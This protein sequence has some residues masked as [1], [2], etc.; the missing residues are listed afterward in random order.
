[1]STTVSPISEHSNEDG[2]IAP[3]AQDE[4]L[5]TDPPFLH[6]ESSNDRNLFN[7]HGSSRSQKTLTN[8]YKE[9]ISDGTTTTL[10]RSGSVLLLVLPYVIVAIFAWAITAVLAFRPITTKSYKLEVNGSDDGYPLKLHSRYVQNERWFE[11]ARVLESIVT[12]L[13]IPVA[14]AVCSSAAVIFAQRGK[15]SSGLS[16]RQT[17][18]L[19]NR[20]WLDLSTYGSLIPGA[21]E[22]AWKRYASTFLV[23]A[24]LLNL[25]GGIIGPLQQ[26]FLSTTNIKTPTVP[27]TITNLHDLAMLSSDPDSDNSDVLFTRQALTTA[28]RNEPQSQLWP[29]INFNSG[30]NELNLMNAHEVAPMACESNGI[31]FGN[32]SQL[33][34]PF[35]AEL[36]NDFNSGVIRQFLP[37]INSTATYQNIDKSNF[38]ANCSDFEGAF[39]ADLSNTTDIAPSFW[40]L[41]ACMPANLTKSPWKATGDRQDFS[42]ELYLNISGLDTG[43]AGD[44]QL[45]YKIVVNTTAGFFELPNY[46][47]GGIAGPLLDRAPTLHP[48]GACGDACEEQELNIIE[49]DQISGKL[50]Y[51]RAE[52]SNNTS[53][54]PNQLEAVPNKGPLLT[55]ALAL[56]GRGSYPTIPST[57]PSNKD[58]DNSN[59]EAPGSCVT[60]V[61]FS[62]LSDVISWQELQCQRAED[63]S[64]FDVDV[65]QWI[66]GFGAEA[67][68]LSNTFTAAAFLANQAWF[69]NMDRNTIAPLFVE[70]DPGADTQVPVISTAGVVV[71]SILLGLFL[72]GLLAMAMYAALTPRWTSKL[73]AWAMM[74]IGAEMSDKFPLAVANNV[75]GVKELDEMPGWIGD[76]GDV[77]GMIAVGGS[78]RVRGGRRYACYPA[79][80]YGTRGPPEAR[81]HQLEP[82]SDTA[83][84]PL[85][86]RD[87]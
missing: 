74:R 52:T 51:R 1:M 5:V 59:N 68:D 26:I 37:R 25:L 12:T 80:R 7:D 42:E 84:E 82:R 29:G 23:I 69:Q 3:R 28:S 61:P 13:T 41:Q 40:A 17:M 11:A 10:H 49:A 87:V 78:D 18:I 21:R 46:M 75:D 56:F 16:M 58:D 64:G 77:V 57:L 8:G 66:Q 71:I 39:F 24:I 47:N 19:A 22:K 67:A 44:T 50:K 15:G 34:N 85:R 70:F 27:T 35:Y 83:L 60:L 33:D 63:H 36:P 62:G 45:Y 55:I 20:G 14:S 30:C 6:T 43:S 48:N 2:Y 32:M 31:T 53:W 9:T 38:P 54:N 81:T 73:D 86:R 65:S 79:D 72:S 76:D 4:V